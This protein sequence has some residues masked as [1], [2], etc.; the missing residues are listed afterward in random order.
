[1]RTRT[2]AIAVTLLLA[3]VLFGTVAEVG[4]AGRIGAIC[5]DGTR[6]F[7]TVRGACS[8][9]GGVARWL[10]ADDSEATP[11]A[12]AEQP[13]SGG[14]IGAVCEDGSRS[15]ATGSG[16]CTHHGGVAY[17][18]YEEVASEHLVELSSTAATQDQESPTTVST[19]ASDQPSQSAPALAALPK[20][21]VL[22]VVAAA[23]S[24][25]HIRL[26]WLDRSDRG[27]LRD[28]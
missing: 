15:T 28:S 24:E 14:R 6:S 1:M 5:K 23:T 18:L 16:A 27:R 12:V 21:P 9:H 20:S 3:I 8:H 22:A 2:R 10:H 7:A 25:L 4:L 17:W 19:T 13:N 11:A 26:A